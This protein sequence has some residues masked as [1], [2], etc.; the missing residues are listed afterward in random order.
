MEPAIKSHE[1][2]QMLLS[3]VLLLRDLER[4]LRV[5]PAFKDRASLPAWLQMIHTSASV[6]DAC[7]LGLR[8]ERD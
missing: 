5:A 1:V 3:I 6:L 7:R 8:M 2:E 4:K